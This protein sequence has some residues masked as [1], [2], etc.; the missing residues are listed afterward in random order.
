MKTVSVTVR[1]GGKGD[2][3]SR[4]FAYEYQYPVD[5]KEA[6][7]S[8]FFTEAEMFELAT[9]EY[10]V[11]RAAPFRPL[12]A[13]GEVPI[14]DIVAAAKL[15]SH[16][17]GRGK[18]ITISTEQGIDFLASKAMEGDDP[19]AMIR[20]LQAKIDAAKAAKLAADGQAESLAEG[21]ERE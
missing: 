3:A 21:T 13:K 16:R 17:T 4:S 9:G 12:L 14:K 10:E 1:Q 5:Y 7:S 20:A 8:G 6:L 18:V 19:E 2:K 15:W 11:R